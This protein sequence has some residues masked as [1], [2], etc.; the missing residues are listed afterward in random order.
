MLFS[1]DILY[2]ML[3]K[4]IWFCINCL[5]FLPSGISFWFPSTII[6]A[7]SLIRRIFPFVSIAKIPWDTLCIIDFNCIFLSVISFIVIFIVSIIELKLFANT[8]ISPDICPLTLLSN[9]LLLISFE[10]F[11]NSFKYDL[12]L[13]LYLTKIIVAIDKINIIKIYKPFKNCASCIFFTSKLFN[14]ILLYLLYITYFILY[15]TPLT[16]SINLL[17]LSPIFF[18]KCLIWTSSVLVA[19]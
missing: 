6:L 1:P 2:I 11:I 12:K 19:P 15:P 18:L 3:S 5:I 14:F 4:T 10:T 16:V 7:K 9:C 8:P 17:S 13:I